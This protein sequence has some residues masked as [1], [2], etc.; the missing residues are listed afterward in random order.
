METTVL[1]QL[2][3]AISTSLIALCGVFAAIY[4]G[5]IPRKRKVK[6]DSLQMELLECYQNIAGL[7]EIE[8]EYMEEES[9]GKKK[10]RANVTLSKKVQPKHVET[11]IRE[12]SEEL[13]RNN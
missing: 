6:M 7:L 3:T 1:I 12:L 11:R 2:I 9:I 10:A 4:W 8:A 5:Y 13:N